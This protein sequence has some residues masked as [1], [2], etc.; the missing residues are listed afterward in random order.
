MP[1]TT[2]P[3]TAPIGWYYFAL[4]RDLTNV[5]T[6]IGWCGRNLVAWLGSSG[7][8]VADATCPH[9]GTSLLLADVVGDALACRRHRGMVCGD[10]SFSLSGT[11]MT[12]P[13]PPPP[14]AVRNGI[15]WAWFGPPGLATHPPR[16]L[17]GLSEPGDAAHGYAPAPPEFAVENFVDGPHFRSLH[18]VDAP[19]V[20]LEIGGEGLRFAHTYRRPGSNR[21]I[22][23]RTTSHGPGYFCTAGPGIT[24]LSS[25]VPRC[26]G[27]TDAHWFHFSGANPS[28]SAAEFLRAQQS[29]SSKMVHE[30]VDLWRHLGAGRQR[31]MDVTHEMLEI[32]RWWD[33]L[34][35]APLA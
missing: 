3:V 5:P 27:G 9:L 34:P 4:E 8:H 33:R 26:D 14:L 22:T 18:G 29:T 13:R 19:S 20:V 32:R 24:T 7:P 21:G 6:G 31:S 23:L 35:R 2:A 30:D 10:G 11:S 16:S 1:G 12:P 28:A 17:P 25:L 15:V